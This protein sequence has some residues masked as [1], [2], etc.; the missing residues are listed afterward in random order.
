M[1]VRTGQTLSDQ[2]IMELFRRLPEPSARDA[3][4]AEFLPLAEYF[5]RRI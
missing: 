2:E 4:A 3:L 1:S 5:G